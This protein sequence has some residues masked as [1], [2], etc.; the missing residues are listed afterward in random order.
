MIVVG[1]TGILIKYNVLYS[2][3]TT[4][5]GAV[6]LLLSKICKYIIHD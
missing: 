4:V 1:E 6:I 2:L 5:T 3:L